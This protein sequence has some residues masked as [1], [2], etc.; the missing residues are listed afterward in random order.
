MNMKNR[1]KWITIA[2]LIF[3]LVIPLATV[4]RNVMPDSLQESLTEE[5]KAILE[6]NG[7]L[8]NNVNNGETQPGEAAGEP[9]EVARETGFAAFQKS[10][11]NFT[12]GLFGR[13]KLIAF[14]TELTSALTGGTYI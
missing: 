12:N 8:I 2:F 10:I 5:E 7:T 3:I 6:N 4:A 13:T 14:N 9:V 11:N 1:D